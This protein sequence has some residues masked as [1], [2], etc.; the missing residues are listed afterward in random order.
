MYNGIRSFESRERNV[1]RISYWGLIRHVTANKKLIDALGND[2]R[3]ELHYY[4]RMQQDG[5]DIQ[6]YAQDKKYTNVF[7]HG[8]Y[9]PEDRYDFAKRTD[10]IHNIYNHDNKVT[11]NAMGNKYYDGAIFHIP[12]ICTEGSFMGELVE[13]NKIGL[14]LNLDDS[15]I[16]DKIWNYY[17]ELDWKT[18]DQN[19]DKVM[20]E[21]IE[22]QYLARMKFL[23]TIG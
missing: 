22:E 16:A 2:S 23:E 3:F 19:C 11:M 5:R 15:N 7:F 13:K 4:G 6:E 9:M 12:Q 14:E 1:I 17:D 21:I 8:Q 18:F 10:L 20:K